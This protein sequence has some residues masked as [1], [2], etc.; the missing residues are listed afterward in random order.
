MRILALIAL[1]L[2]AATALDPR[3]TTLRGPAG[4]PRGAT[5]IAF[6]LPLIPITR[7]LSADLQ[8]ARPPPR[9]GPAKPGGPLQ[10]GGILG[11]SARKGPRRALPC[12]RPPT[13]AA[14]VL[15]S[16]GGEEAGGGGEAAALRAWLEERGVVVSDQVGS[17]LA[18]ASPSPSF[19][20]C[21]SVC[22]RTGSLGVWSLGFRG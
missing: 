6:A 2:N 15:M 1:I 7:P 10:R 5:R 9:A 8:H 18:R 3:D 16:A 21:L 14:G 11:P 20:V 13:R 17:R 12:L 22:E 19:P 4:R